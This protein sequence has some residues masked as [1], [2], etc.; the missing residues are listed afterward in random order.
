MSGSTRQAATRILRQL[1]HPQRHYVP[2]AISAQPPSLVRR[3]ITQQY[4]QQQQKR[5]LSMTHPVKSNDAFNSK[6]SGSIEKPPTTVRE[7]SAT[8]AEETMVSDL[9]ENAKSIE[10]VIA[11]LHRDTRIVAPATYASNTPSSLLLDGSAFPAAAD[12]TGYTNA[13]AEGPFSSSASEP[14]SP[15]SSPESSV[16]AAATPKKRSRFWFYIYHI[17]YWS[18]LGSLPV[19]LLMFKGEAKEVKEKQEWRIGV[20]T[21]MRDKLQRGESVEE[22][23]ALLSVGMNRN[24]REEQVDDNAGIR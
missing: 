22:E 4:C 24:Q 16:G 5:C 15:S 2:S 3:S 14:R 19:H 1:G 17:L 8:T 7:P 13:G 9:Q 18:A 6:P 23:E 21:E 11:E 10:Q 20:L 12:H